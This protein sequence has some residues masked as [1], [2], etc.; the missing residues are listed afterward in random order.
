MIRGPGGRGHSGR[1]SGVSAVINILSRTRPD[2]TAAG[3][4]SAA[5]LITP[6]ASIPLGGWVLQPEC[7][8]RWGITLTLNGSVTWGLRHHPQVR[9]GRPSALPVCSQHSCLYSTV[10]SFLSSLVTAQ[11]IPPLANSPAWL[12]RLSA[13]AV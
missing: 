3:G 11:P 6:H 2:W 1:G 13:V 5:D 12:L 8:G 10:F 7:C 4:S 9:T